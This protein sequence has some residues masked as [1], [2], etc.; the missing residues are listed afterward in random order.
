MAN[1]ALSV[2]LH[3]DHEV[4][5]HF[6][7]LCNADNFKTDEIAT[8]IQSLIDQFGENHQV[9]VNKF[10]FY[11]NDNRLNPVHVVR[12]NELTNLSLVLYILLFVAMYSKGDELR[13]NTVLGAFEHTSIP[14]KLF[15]E[16][17]ISEI[18]ATTYYVRDNFKVNESGEKED[19]R[20]KSL[21]YREVGRGICI[22]MF[23]THP[24]QTQKKK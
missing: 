13:M 6:S 11:A 2:D 23:P 3:L 22:G 8:K 7:L 9:S 12:L 21:I 15:T 19:I 1:K 16:H 17:Y 4:G 18:V 20:D 5:S 24:F 10:C 14:P